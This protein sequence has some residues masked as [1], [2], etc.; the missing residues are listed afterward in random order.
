MV[1]SVVY[2][3]APESGASENCAV[4]HV[5]CA[6]MLMRRRGRSTATTACP[7]CRRPAPP[8]G[9][10]VDNTTGTSLLDVRSWSHGARRPWSVDRSSANPHHCRELSHC[11]RQ[12]CLPSPS[13]PSREGSRVVSTP[14]ETRAARDELWI[15]VAVIVLIAA[16]ST[17][18]IGRSGA[19][20]SDAFAA[21]ASAAISVV[22]TFA[23]A[24]GGHRLGSAGRSQERQRLAFLESRVSAY[25]SHLSNPDA[26]DRDIQPLDGP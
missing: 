26:I 25:R 6:L 5:E 21:I 9:N 17:V 16:V 4:R 2:R 22:G 3:L 15:A 14:P 20:K 11:L 8:G 10:P 19:D 18:A 13:V 24:I 23:A 12:L 1:P 7:P